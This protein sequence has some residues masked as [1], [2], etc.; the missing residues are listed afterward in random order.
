MGLSY[1]FTFS[2]P[3]K[4]KPEA[5]LKF[6]RGVEE[7]AKKIGFNPTRVLNASFDTAERREFARRL[8]TGYPVEDERLK[9]VSLVAEGQLWHHGQQS[10]T[11]HVIPSRGVVLIVTNER[12]CETVF[13]FLQYP[14]AIKDL[15]GKVVAVTVCVVDGS[16]GTLSTAQIRATGRSS[17]VSR[18]L[19]TSRRK[20]TS[21]AE[22]KKEPAYGGFF[23]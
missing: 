4:T 8:T 18:R 9:G 14:A 17:S 22:S 19:D 13:G 7:E 20:R 15:N 23:F 12:Q 1:L 6:L 2:A 3:A 5:L 16:F 11:A 10:G 21:S